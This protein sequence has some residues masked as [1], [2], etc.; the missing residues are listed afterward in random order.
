MEL[1][2]LLNKHCDLTYVGEVCPKCGSPNIDNTTNAEET[3]ND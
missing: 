3:N 1:P 2:K